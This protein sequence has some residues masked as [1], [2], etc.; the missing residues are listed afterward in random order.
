MFCA[1]CGSALPDGAGFCLNC[2]ANTADTA[3][4]VENPSREE[5]T[6]KN[7]QRTFNPK[8]LLAAA[9][10]V[11]V[12]VVA[13]I[14]VVN[15]FK[16][17]KYEK[18]KGAVAIVQDNGTV[19]VVPNGKSKIE[20]D[21]QLR[22]YNLNMDNTIAAITI[23]E[24]NSS[25]S[26]DGYSLYLITDK[27]QLISDGVYSFWLAASGSAVAYT[28]NSDS[29][30]HTAELWIYS[31]GKNTK[32][33]TDFYS[34]DGCALSPDGKAAAFV[35]TDSSGK[36]TG[37]IW[38]GKTT[39]L[40]KDIEPFAISNGAKYIY[41]IR[42]NYIRNNTYYVQKGTNT[43][44]REK[45]C[46]NMSNLFANKDFSQIVYS[47]NSN[48]YISVNGGGRQTLSGV[49]NEFVVPDSSAAFNASNTDMV[50]YGIS[51]FADTYYQN[52]ANTLVYINN[53]LESS[54]VARGVSSA[55]LADNGK[56]LTYLRSG[57]IYKKRSNN[58]NAQDEKI[59]NKDV[60]SFAA[61]A[62]GNSVF[63]TTADELFYQK[64]KGKP[65][66]VSNDLSYRNAIPSISLFKGSTLFFISDDELY[67]STGGKGR[68][69]G[70]VDGSVSSVSANKFAV[71]A[72]SVDTNSHLEYISTDG[73]SFKLISQN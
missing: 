22:E 17:A 38:N 29:K 32:L 19:A 34:G 68:L 28:K 39:D 73:N 67:Y 72:R 20:I 61:T 54:N 7:K 6:S 13:I 31:D 21:G 42:N 64:G 18:I 8:K 16:P 12:V 51:G 30:A 23:R 48:T 57:T 2:G 66:T 44:T 45:L 53:K 70:G 40:G 36:N 63:Y 65:V 11:V 25:P 69:A 10:A 26:T 27:S 59:V 47:D 58:A 37:V 55:F 49:V 33:S 60:T 52:S 50:I 24:N 56:T 71:Y 4:N 43:D 62:D 3:E 35:T 15:I 41:Y 9:I 46:D 1:Y 5:A 14:V